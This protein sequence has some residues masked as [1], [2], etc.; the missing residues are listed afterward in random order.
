MSALPMNFDSAFAR[1]RYPEPLR[2]TETMGQRVNGRYEKADLPERSIAAVVL[3]IETRR[4]EFLSA[5]DASVSGINIIT[6]DELYFTDPKADEVEN[7]Q[8]F[9]HYKGQVYR[10]VVDSLTMKNTNYNGY[11]CLRYMDLQ[12]A[13]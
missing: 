2:V 11:D 3:A 13:H 1:F 10:V 6:K 7:R 12:D 9:V 8:S 5:G 4:L